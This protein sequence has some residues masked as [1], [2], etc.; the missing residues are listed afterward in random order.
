MKFD[1]WILKPEHENFKLNKRV[2]K[3]KAEMFIERLKDIRDD[4]K[5]KDY[6][7][8]VDKVSALKD[9]IK[10]YRTAGLDNGGEFSLEN[11]VFKVLRRTPFMDILDSYKAK[12]Y[13]KL[14]SVK[15]TIKE[16]LKH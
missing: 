15:E 2:I 12:A 13:D 1:K 10:K 11:L 16:S 7:S 14:M 5:A 6:Q 4:Y 9:K 3:N 8:V